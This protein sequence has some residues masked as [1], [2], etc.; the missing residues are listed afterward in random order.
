M[1]GDITR[2]ENLTLSR[3]PSNIFDLVLN[4]IS[5][6]SSK[7]M[8]MG[9]ILGMNSMK[10]QKISVVTST[11]STVIKTVESIFTDSVCIYESEVLLYK[12][13]CK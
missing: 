3:V 11:R 13:A 2:L 10:N 8:S 9:I 12:R 4:A 1:R 6:S 7:E 5:A